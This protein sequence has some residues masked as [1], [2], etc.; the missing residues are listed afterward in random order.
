VSFWT[1]PGTGSESD[2]K[3]QINGPLQERQV[4]CW[5]YTEALS[6]SKMKSPFSLLSWKLSFC[7]LTKKNNN[8]KQNA[9]R[10]QMQQL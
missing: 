9:N 2:G 8:R 5:K 6:E 3:A 7:R 1:E 10:K 4:F